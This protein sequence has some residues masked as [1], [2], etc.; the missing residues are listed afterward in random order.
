MLVE[1]A[2]Q[3]ARDSDN[4]A[5][6]SA[7]LINC[8]REPVVD[9][10]VTQHIIKPVL[11]LD[12]FA[13]L[14]GV[15]VRAM[16]VMDGDL[17]AVIGDELIQIN[18][19]GSGTVLDT[20][21]TGP[22]TMAGNN[23][24]LGIVSGGDYFA[25]DGATLTEP[26]PGAFSSFGAVEYFGNYT[27]LTELDGRRFQWS[28]IADATDLPGT[29]F[30]TAD[31]RDDNLVRPMRINGQL[32]LFKEESHEVW[33]LTG[34]SGAEAFERVVGGVYDLGLAGPDLIARFPDGAFMVASDGKAYIVAGPRSL[35]PVST[36]PVET[37]IKDCDPVRCFYYEDEGHMMC[38]IVFRDC[39]AWCFDI[40]T[41]EWHERAEGFDLGPWTATAS[42]KWRD[43]WYVGNES[44][45]ISLM[46]RRTDDN[47]VDLIKEA[48][49]T[50]AY[51]D[52]ARPV[53]QEVEVF[54]KQGFTS[55]SVGL[56]ISRDNGITWSAEKVR[57][58]SP[59]GAYANRM[60]W[61]RQGQARQF[62]ARLRWTDDVAINS[63]AR[64][65]V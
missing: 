17:F 45:T 65:T 14:G 31:G 40:A 28:D 36:P 39:P 30:S 3:S 26:T 43:R 52:G 22:A 13:V 42:A 34:G 2:G 35:Q 49:S 6:G 21:N 1:F 51:F 47:G 19:D 18:T 64:V 24:V 53:I 50:T 23:S 46:E 37:A 7:R 41:G 9:Q 55:G 25:W 16:S 32:F 54:P 59:I 58:L 10:G 38:Q 56:A 4:R 62:T 33:Y 44:G 11:G 60:V 8:Y 57:S 5:A 15:F 48:T 63:I 27:V 61:R 20:V 29:N 12:P